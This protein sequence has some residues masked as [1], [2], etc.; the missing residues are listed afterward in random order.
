MMVSTQYWYDTDDNKRLYAK[1]E[2]YP[3]KGFRP[4]KARIEALKKQKIITEVK[5]EKKE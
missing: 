4:T 2:E 5:E 1:G 3:R